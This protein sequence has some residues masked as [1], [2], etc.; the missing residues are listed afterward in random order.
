MM[1]VLSCK[2]I[3]HAVRALVGVLPLLIGLPSAAAGP[4]L[5]RQQPPNILLVIMDDV[6]ID[7]MPA[8]GYGGLVQPSMPTIDSIAAAGV[9]FRNHW[10]MPECSPGRAVLLT[11]QFP[12][13]SNILQAI[14]PNDLAN[15][16]VSPYA[17]TAAKL[18]QG[19]GY[20]S[21]MFGK[22][23]LAGPENNQAGNGAPAQLGWR[24]FHG[25]TGGLPGSIDT[26]AGGVAPAGTYSCGFVP[27][28]S[29]PGGADTGACYV[30]GQRASSCAVLS[31][32]NPLGDAPG[33]QCLARGGVFV[34]HATCADTV[35][36]EVTFRRQNA[37]YVSPLVINTGGR[38]E[39]ASLDDMRGRGFRATIEVDA[40][41]RWIQQ[42]AGSRKPWMA[43]VSFSIDHT[44]LQPPPGKLLPSGIGRRL[45]ADCSNPLNQRLLSD[46][47]I[48]AMD[49]ELGRLLTH[50]GIARRVAS[51]LV[52]DPAASNTVL[53]IVG[54]NGSL[55]TTVKLPLD[56]ARAKSTA[57]QTGVWV[58]LV[59]AGPPVRAPDRDVE[60]M[61]NQADLFR[62]FGELAGLTGQRS[63]EWPRDT[64]PLLPYLSNPMQPGLRRFNFTQGGLNLQVDGGRNGACV[65]GG[66]FCS[67]TPVTKS[68]CEDN[69]GQWWSSGADAPGVLATL[70]AANKTPVD[71]KECWQVNQALYQADPASYEGAQVSM[72]PLEY[73]GVRN[74]AFK[75][76]RNGYSEYDVATDGERPVLD[77][78]FYAVDQDRINPTLDRA[79][80]DLLATGSLTE[81]EQANFAELR[82]YLEAVLASQEPCPGDGNRDGFVDQ[83]DLANYHSVALSWGLSSVY[84]FNLD[85]LT[86][87]ADLAIIRSNWGACQR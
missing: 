27:D 1:T 60:H 66:S 53:I 50:T 41:I 58:P 72:L 31:D 29:E 22:F 43:T 83:R 56:P 86:D 70:T 26:T 47:M 49:T 21:A 63:V 80:T 15:S 7:Q 19:A 8:F 18:L 30:P 36:P 62:L 40:A 3:G 59:V 52:Y 24:H 17:L 68:V 16:Q 35:P 44:P 37:H 85:G 61:T 13:R 28:G 67:H 9:R 39:E 5:A 54:D 87:E 38:V 84:D 71:I 46:A 32:N 48:E 2:R 82:Q 45:G 77:E 73:T 81:V 78:E 57:Y 11:G 69:G 64:E 12:L 74:E 75:L 42:Q 65:L 6:G 51:R 4:D 14:G 33:L 23:H 55:G 76:V 20:T 10:A 25:W 79:G 34:P